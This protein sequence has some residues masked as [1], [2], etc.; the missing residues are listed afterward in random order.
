[1]IQAQRNNVV[2]MLLV[3]SGAPLSEGL[4][5]MT[6]RHGG[7]EQL[8]KRALNEGGYAEVRCVIKYRRWPYARVGY[9]RR[10][11]S[12][13]DQYEFLYCDEQTSRP[14]KI[15]IFSHGYRPDKI[16]ALFH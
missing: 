15:P 1:M 2:R 8:V 10:T 6:L 13:T 4:E 5:T 9:V 3:D 16:A 11:E 12:Q 7:T 14:T